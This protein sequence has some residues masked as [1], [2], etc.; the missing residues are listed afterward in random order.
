V[1]RLTLAIVVTCAVA[2]ACSRSS[3]PPSGAAGENAAAPAAAQ[4]ASQPA[5]Q[6][7]SQAAA[8]PASEQAAQPAPAATTSAAKTPE[9]APATSATPTSGAATPPDSAPAVPPPPPEPAFH[10]VTIPAETLLAVTLATPIASDTSHVE[11]AISGTLAKSIVVDGRTA[12]PVG[13]KITGSV[14]EA[15]GSKRVKGRA[16]VAFRFDHLVVRGER[17]SIQTDRVAREAAADTKGDVKKG[18]LGAGAGA[19]IGGI[20]GG[21]KG[22]AIGGMVGGA[23]AV[24]ATKGKEVRLAA[25]DTVS[26]KLREPLRVMV[27]T[28]RR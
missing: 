10:E 27:P 8:P 21:G 16:S 9:T 5:T 12:V 18:G 2:T 15:N 20:A 1:T 25:G 11:D 7:A 23:G 14:L 22:A 17:H 19:V 24:M 3:A 6:P 26:T 13:S 4:P 28:G